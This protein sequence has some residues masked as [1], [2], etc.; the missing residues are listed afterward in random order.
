[1]RTLTEKYN[2]VLNETFS[3]SQ[4]VRDARMAL[5][6]LITQFNGFED[7]V[8][9]LKSKGMIFEAKKEEYTPAPN[10]SL[11]ALDSA[12]QYE[13][14]LMNGDDNNFTEEQ[15]AKAKAKAE[16]N[17]AKNANHYINLISGESKHVNK[18]DKE[19]EVKRG[20]AAKDT[21]NDLK[22]ADLRESKRAIMKEE[23]SS[24]I[25][26]AKSYAASKW[27]ELS[28]K[29]VMDFVRMHGKEIMDGD[30]LEASFDNYVYANWDLDESTLKEAIKNIIR[31]TL[32]EQEVEEISRD[33]YERIDGLTSQPLLA[34]LLD[35]AKAIYNDQIESGDLF[36]AEDVS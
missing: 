15:A 18:H 32:T 19:V 33:A 24:I 2:G 36:D 17:L 23:L 30:D 35:T 29:D 34:Q 16:K 3:K 5:P 14:T 1:M 12:I 6:N 11:D 26:Q 28:D 8:A 25:N 27:P 31:K 4:F 9:I 20:E 21:F 13:L 7:A 10:Y 22:K